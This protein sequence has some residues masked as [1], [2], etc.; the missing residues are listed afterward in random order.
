MQKTASVATQS[1][2]QKHKEDTSEICAQNSFVTPNPARMPTTTL[3]DASYTFILIWQSFHWFTSEP[4]FQNVDKNKACKSPQS[5]ECLHRS[6]HSSNPPT[7]NPQK[8]MVSQTTVMT[9][10]AGG[11]VGLVKEKRWEIANITMTE[12]PLHK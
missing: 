6:V 5:S 3:D 10:L 12:K 7:P 11:A 8:P 4:P 2:K 1:S 9:G